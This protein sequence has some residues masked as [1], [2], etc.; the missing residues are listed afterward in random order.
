MEYNTDNPL[1]VFEAFAGYGSQA[2]ALE[3]LK[4]KYPPFDYKVVGIS[5]IDKHAIK[6]YM[7]VHGETNNYGD[8]SKI[9]W[10]RGGQIP[11]FD[12]FTYSFPCQSVSAAGKQEGF[13]EGSGTTSS[14]LWECR[15]A[16]DIKRPKY[17][18]MENVKALVSKKFMPEFFKWCAVLERFG[19]RNYWQV[20]NAKDYGVPQNRER[21][22]MVSIRNDIDKEFVFPTK[23]PLTR[24]LKD[25]LEPQVDEKYYLSAERVAGLKLSTN[26]EASR[27]NGFKFEPKSADDIANSVTT[28]GSSRKTD[29]F[30]QEQ[31]PMI[32][33]YSRSNK[34]KGE[35]LNR[36]L[37]DT[38]N[39]IT[40]SPS[41]NT[42][43]YVYEHKIAASRGRGDN[44]EQH[45]EIR[46]DDVSNTITTVQKDNMVVEPRCIKVGD[47]ADG[48]NEMC[49]RVYS[50]QGVSPAITTCCGGGHEPKI[51]EYEQNFRIRKL[52]ERESFRLMDVG[53]E[54]IDKIQAAGISKTQ[55]NHM[56]GNSI[57]V[58]CLEYIFHNMFISDDSKSTEPRQLSLF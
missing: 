52:T 16:I 48:G 26:K 10:S 41:N 18:L 34:G 55:Q 19:Y 37:K 4:K 50:A 45:L 54:D 47:L 17:L 28:K 43:Q 2:M 31:E 13:V 15:R 42:M 29:D 35:I 40:A 38:A 22:F 39:C 1:L 30:I 58:C 7:A 20:M 6:A 24:R 9:D 56:A 33:G 51:A 49:R 46:K 32:V 14:L 27:G 44:N 57:V 21:V 25:V 23:M 3:R 11:D 36:H 5:E 12:L 53:D 8:I